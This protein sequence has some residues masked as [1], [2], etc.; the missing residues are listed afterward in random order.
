MTA[1]DGLPEPFRGYPSYGALHEIVPNQQ[2]LEFLFDFNTRAYE[3]FSPMDTN[4]EVITDLPLNAKVEDDTRARSDSYDPRDYYRVFDSD[5]IGLSVLDMDPS[6][7]KARKLHALWEKNDFGATEKEAKNEIDRKLPNT[8]LRVVYDKV[9]PIGGFL[10]TAHGGREARQK[11]ALVPAVEQSIELNRL[12]TD[13]ADIVVKAIRRRFEQ[14][15][16]P[17]DVVP[18]TTFAAFKPKASDE[19][20]KGLIEET[21]KGLEQKPVGARLGRLVFRHKS[22]RALKH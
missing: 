2:V 12:I 16:A 20:I 22:S 17:W 10:P 9:M 18:V 15:T 4:V 21:N 8:P 5:T 1:R 11:V 7:S 6:A 19:K 14:F 13:E 3:A